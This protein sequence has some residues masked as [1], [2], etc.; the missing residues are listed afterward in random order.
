M[1]SS[2]K[3]ELSNCGRNRQQPCA[4]IRHVIARA[5]NLSTIHLIGDHI[6][7]ETIPLNEDL[8]ITTSPSDKGRILGSHCCEYAFSVES[9]IKVNISNIHFNNIGVLNMTVA[10]TI[11]TH[12]IHV[13]DCKGCVFN[14]TTVGNSSGHLSVSQHPCY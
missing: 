14:L 9:S 2:E 4:N 3:E 12:N 5:Q 7:K 11:S 13:T 10:S 6:I 8:S 1:D